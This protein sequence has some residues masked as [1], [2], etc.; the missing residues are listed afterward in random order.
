[1]ENLVVY[2]IRR[3]LADIPQHP[4]PAGYFTKLYRPGDETAWVS[5]NRAADK[6]NDISLVM[7]GKQFNDDVE[8][9]KS[10]C[11]FLC[12]EG[13]REIGTASAW[14]DLNYHGRDF[15]R[16][17]WVAILP[18]YQRKGLAKPMMTVVMNRMAEI[19]D[20]AYL[21][22]GTARIP[23]VKVYLDFGF[24]PDIW[25]ED[26]ARRWAIVGTRLDHPVLCNSALWHTSP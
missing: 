23:A 25:H 8:S 20:R 3:R 10:R 18:E 26:D 6:F 11:F 21:T 14:Y 16:V 22:T 1:M 4:M 2:M 7:F 24:V 19:H 17:H 13:G 9:L 15:G 5:I 12:E